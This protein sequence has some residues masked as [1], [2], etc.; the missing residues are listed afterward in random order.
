MVVQVVLDAPSTPGQYICDRI[1][2]HDDGAAGLR[3]SFTCPA[4]SN[5][6]DFDTGHGKAV[7]RYLG[8]YPDFDKRQLD[9]IKEGDKEVVFKKFLLVEEL[10]EES[11][12]RAWIENPPGVSRA[13]KRE[14]PQVSYV[15]IFEKVCSLY[16]EV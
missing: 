1:G 8:L 9:F 6:P 16:N 11:P 5:F 2:L 7:E 12:F 13:Y 4:L 14:R 3:F 15:E 10:D